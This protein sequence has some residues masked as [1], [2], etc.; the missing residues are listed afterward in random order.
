[1]SNNEFPHRYYVILIAGSFPFLYIF[2]QVG[3]SIFKC[4]GDKVAAFLSYTDA[5]S[6]FVYGPLVSKQYL[7]PQA[8]RDYGWNS[9]IIPPKEVETLAYV[10]EGLNSC[11][12]NLKSAMYCTSWNLFMLKIVFE[13]LYLTRY[14]LSLNSSLCIHGCVYVQDPLG[15]IFL[16][17]RR[18]NAFLCWCTAMGSNEGNIKTS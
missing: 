16:L 15:D 2:I 9:S 5:G 13:G 7:F 4:L 6:S 8:I 10:A 1:M 12:F 11:M 14:F 3:N 17:L 18:I